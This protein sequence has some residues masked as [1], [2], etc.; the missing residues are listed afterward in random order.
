MNPWKLEFPRVTNRATGEELL[1]LA[2]HPI[3]HAR[4]GARSTHAEIVGFLRDGRTVQ[5]VVPI[6]DLEAGKRNPVRLLEAR[7]IHAP[8]GSI[9]DFAGRYVRSGHS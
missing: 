5:I 4:P 8:S 7:D 3:P 6:E 2:H 9:V 1:V